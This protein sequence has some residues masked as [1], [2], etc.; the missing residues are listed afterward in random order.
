MINAFFPTLK[1]P[2]EGSPLWYKNFHNSF[3]ISQLVNNILLSYMDSFINIVKLDEIIKSKEKD[4]E[5]AGEL[6]RD[7]DFNIIYLDHEKIYSYDVEQGLN[8]LIANF[9][10]QASHHHYILEC[11]GIDAGNYMDRDVE[12]ILDELKTSVDAESW[13]KIV[14]G[15][16]NV[17]EFLFL[18]SCAESTLKS[19]VGDCNYNTSDLVGKM[20]KSFK[21]ISYFM[22]EN[23]KMNK[24]FML[25]LWD[26][27]CFIR[28]VYSHTHGVLSIPNKQELIKKS[29]KFKIEFENAFH[30]D[31]LL[32]SIVVET[33]KIFR[34]DA[35]KLGKFYLIS[36]NELNIFRNFISE[37]MAALEKF[38]IEKM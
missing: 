29:S 23:H 5:E 20:L 22:E 11:M 32:S 19:I 37:F 36:D 30:K 15:F 18:F 17:W 28:N 4:L 12:V 38:S 6:V 16:L 14:K 35:A 1:M 24:K 31:I 7:A 10:I 9:K 8:E 34:F 13:Y 27:Y 21:G 33:N 3:Y 25:S 26:L 2:S